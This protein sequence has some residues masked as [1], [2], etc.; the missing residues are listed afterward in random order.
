MPANTGRMDWYVVVKIINGHR[1]RYRQKTWR[2]GKQ[3]RC[4][5]HYLGRCNTTVRGYHG[6]FAKFD[7]FDESKLG[8]GAGGPDTHAGFFFASNAR[9][10]ISYAST[11]LAAQRGLEVTI[12][13]LEV[14]VEASTGEKWWDAEELLEKGGYAHDKA[15][16]NKLKTYL[17]RIER[18]RGRL[19]DLCSRGIFDELELS[20]RAHLKECRIAMK[21]AYYFDNEN[22]KYS[23][24][25]YMTAIEQRA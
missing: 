22:R 15:T 1:Y 6:T 19:R 18:A 3:I 24:W 2:A 11:E 16:E 14:R 4:A 20:K 21:D 9:V 23:P 5:S 10:A 12:R 8:S 7:R 13:T 17:Q 25:T